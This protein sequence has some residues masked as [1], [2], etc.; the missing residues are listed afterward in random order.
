MYSIYDHKAK[1]YMRPFFVPNREVAL[2]VVTD[3]VNDS[4]HEIGK[5]P[6]DYAL[7]YLG[8]WDDNSA[9][10]DNNIGQFGS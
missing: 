9:E 7:F 8:E 4:E 3:L 10:F 1:M 2:R 6:E 5:H